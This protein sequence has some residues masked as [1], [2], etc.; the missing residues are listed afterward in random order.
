MVKNYINMINPDHIKIE[1]IVKDYYKA[2]VEVTDPISFTFSMGGETGDIAKQKLLL[3]LEG[4]PY[5]HLDSQKWL[6]KYVN[7]SPKD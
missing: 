5:R 2:T 6:I 3:S 4:K 1:K 7:G